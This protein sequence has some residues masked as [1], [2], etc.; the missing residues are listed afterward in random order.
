M[1]IVIENQSN[2]YIQ[3][4]A[5]EWNILDCMYNKVKKKTSFLDE[6][7]HWDSSNLSGPSKWS[8]LL[9]KMFILYKAQHRI[10]G[11]SYLWLLKFSSFHK[12]CFTGVRVIGKNLICETVLFS[13]LFYE[14]K[15]SKSFCLKQARFLNRTCTIRIHRKL[16][17]KSNFQ[18][19]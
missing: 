14:M 8:R 15:A 17:W 10:F 16:I 6:E 19:I 4:R 3:R 9:W 13:C 11:V 18:S 12:I 5:I 1:G 7:E 2:C